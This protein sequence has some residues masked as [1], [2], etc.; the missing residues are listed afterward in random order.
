MQAYLATIAKA[1][2]PNV[3]PVMRGWVGGMADT[4]ADVTYFSRILQK[5]LNCQELKKTM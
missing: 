4:K 5:D 3:I 1:G 2:D